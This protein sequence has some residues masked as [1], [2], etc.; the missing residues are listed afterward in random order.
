MEL[1][2]VSLPQ[3]WLWTIQ[4]ISDC[5]THILCTALLSIHSSLMLTQKAGRSASKTFKH[6]LRFMRTLMQR[7]LSV[8][9]YKLFL[10]APKN[11]YH[12]H[13]AGRHI[14]MLGGDN[15]CGHFLQGHQP[16]GK[17]C[18]PIRISHGYNHDGCCTSMAGCC[19]QVV[20]LVGQQRAYLPCISAR[21]EGR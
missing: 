3:P 19:C 21:S 6:Y 9:S 13:L 11:A 8:T 16:L 7:R 2:G 5:P 20:V 12:G 14:I 15:D 10:R 4:D 17:I 18:Q 1:V